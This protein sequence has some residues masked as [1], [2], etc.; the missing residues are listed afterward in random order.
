M[1]S[2]SQRE[3]TVGYVGVAMNVNMIIT[4]TAMPHWNKIIAV[5]SL[6]F[7]PTNFIGGLRECTF[8]Q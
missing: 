4:G 2:L 8:V 3:A 7:P 5:A 1:L 6:P